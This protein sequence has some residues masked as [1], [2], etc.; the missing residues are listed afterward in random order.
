MQ[1]EIETL[2]EDY[3][4]TLDHLRISQHDGDESE[5]DNANCRLAD[6]A[7]DLK[8]RRPRVSADVKWHNGKTTSTEG[9]LDSIRGD[10]VYIDSILGIVE[11][12]VAS[13]AACSRVED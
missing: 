6:I 8:K 12:T 11:G 5:V 9:I 7:I 13:L 4:N 1:E 2:I 3:Q 10:K